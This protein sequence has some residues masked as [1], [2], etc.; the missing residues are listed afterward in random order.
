MNVNNKPSYALC[1]RL[2]HWKT[3]YEWDHKVLGPIHD[4]QGIEQGLGVPLHDLDVASI[5][6]ADD[7][8]LLADN[9]SSLKNLLTLTMDYY[10][11]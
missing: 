8:V 7:C 10:K 6:Q 3:F 2:M 9:I 5:G 1:P 11:K 4:Q